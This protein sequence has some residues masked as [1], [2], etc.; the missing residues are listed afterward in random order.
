MAWDS[1]HLFECPTRIFYGW[2]GSAQAGER[3]RELGVRR[4]L[5]VT[6]QG[7]RSAGAVDRIAEQIGEN[8]L[9]RGVAAA[10]QHQFGIAAEQA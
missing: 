2:G 8:G 1:V 7:L 6:D 10:V 5:L 3:L 9:D 4:A